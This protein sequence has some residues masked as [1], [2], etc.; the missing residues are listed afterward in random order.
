MVELEGKFGNKLHC[1]LHRGD[2]G[3]FEVFVDGELRAMLRVPLAQGSALV[4]A[5]KGVQSQRTAHKDDGSL[6]VR[7]DPAVL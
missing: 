4:A 1:T 5:A 3:A 6:R 2:G 7:V